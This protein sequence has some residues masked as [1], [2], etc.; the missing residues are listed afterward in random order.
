MNTSCNLKQKGDKMKTCYLCG[1]QDEADELMP[2][3]GRTLFGKLVNEH[4]GYFCSDCADLHYVNT[5]GR[6][7]LEVHICTPHGSCKEVK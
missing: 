1:Y 3:D 7:K 5:C 4:A 2:A 6:L